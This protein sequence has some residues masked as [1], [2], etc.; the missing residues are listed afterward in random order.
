[1]RQVHRHRP[2]AA[3]EQQVQDPQGDAEGQFDGLCLRCRC[4]LDVVFELEAA[5]PW[6]GGEGGDARADRWAVVGHEPVEDGEGVG[7]GG[8]AAGG[9]ADRS[10][11]V[12]ALTAG[13]PPP[14][15][16][17]IECCGGVLER[18]DAVGQR[19]EPI[20]AAGISRW[21]A[22]GGQ[23]CAAVAA[24]LG[25]ELV[26]AGPALCRGSRSRLR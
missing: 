14:E 5:Q 17:R 26:V 9:Q 20:V 10:E 21:D 15:I 7:D 12:D 1:V 19:D 2:V 8:R 13:Q 22:R 6:V 18:T 16:R 3:A 23:Q 24:E 25:D 4:R 11:D